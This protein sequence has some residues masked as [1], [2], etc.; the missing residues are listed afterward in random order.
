MQRGRPISGLEVDLCTVGQ[1]ETDHLLVRGG[2]S[3]VKDALAILKPVVD[4][5][6]M[7]EQDLDNLPL[8][9]PTA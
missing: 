5:R 2:R 9:A 3:K 8:T 7:L 4:V 6:S 1:E